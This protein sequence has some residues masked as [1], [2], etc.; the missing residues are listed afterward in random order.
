MAFSTVAGRFAIG[1]VSV[2]TG[3]PGSAW[4]LRTLSALE[5]I[6]N[7]SSLAAVAIEHWLETNPER[8]IEIIFSN[9]KESMLRGS[10]IVNL[11]IFIDGE[12]GSRYFQS[13]LDPEFV[14]YLCNSLGNAVTS[15]K[16]RVLD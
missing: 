10:G 1:G 8:N 6:Y 13:D 2:T 16:W 14:D 7:S 3:A 15:L 4:Y 9:Y 12:N 11:S 5:H